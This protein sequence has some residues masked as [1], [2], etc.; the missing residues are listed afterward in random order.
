MRIRKSPAVAVFAAVL[1]SGCA[2]DVAQSD[3]DARTRVA[4]ADMP[5]SP[6]K[7]IVPKSERKA[8][9]QSDSKRSAPTQPP[10][11][12]STLQ[13]EASCAGVENCTSVLKAMVTA[14]DR[15]WLRRPVAPMVLANGVR[16]FAYRALAPALSCEELGVALA[17]VRLATRA[18]QGPI[19]GLADDK[20]ERVRSLSAEVE[21]ELR[22]ERRRRCPE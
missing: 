1:L 8:I 5:A 12:A 15:S 21:S 19:P 14:R 16:L 7:T 13:G 20:V 11:P 10:A 3:S 18:F 6:A 2:L 17:E 4:S 9:A 22:A